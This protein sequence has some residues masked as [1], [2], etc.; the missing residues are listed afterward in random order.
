MKRCG[1]KGG[2]EGEGGGHGGGRAMEGGWKRAGE[3][4][5]SGLCRDNDL[6][7]GSASH[8]L[9]EMLREE[10]KKKNS[11]P[12]LERGSLR[13]MNEKKTSRIAIKT[14]KLMRSTQKL[15]PPPA[16]SLSGGIKC[17]PPPPTAAEE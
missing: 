1:L 3:G 4:V 10:R 11:S 5:R 16:A 8:L 14:L 2:R 6:L 13:L 12:L 9:F 7:G 15:P 17:R